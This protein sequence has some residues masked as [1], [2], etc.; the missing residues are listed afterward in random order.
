MKFNQEKSRVKTLDLFEKVWAKEDYMIT[1][2]G[3]NL[4]WL[5]QTYGWKIISLSMK[6]AAISK[7]LRLL[8]NWT[9]FLLKLNKHHGPNFVVKYL[10]ASQLALM[11]KISGVPFSSL[12]ELEP[13]LPL[14]RLTQSGLPHFLSS[15]DRSAILQGSS[16][17]FQLWV[18]LLSI[19]RVLKV[20]GKLKL[21]TITDPFKGD[22]GILDKV[23]SFLVLFSKKVWSASG[24]S[25][26]ISGGKLLPLQTA[27]PSSKVSWLGWYEDAQS[28]LLGDLS[29]VFL[30]YLR[31]TKNDWLIQQFDLALSVRD[32]IFC[33][34]KTKPEL[35]E[36]CLPGVRVPLQHNN[37]RVVSS[38]ILRD[39]GKSG[40]LGALSLKR[41]PAGKIRVFAMVDVW[42]QSALRPLHDRIFQFLA[43]LP[44]DGTFDQD[45]SFRRAQA[46]AV[47]AGCSYG[48]D[49]SAATDRLPLSLQKV[50]L[51]SIFGEGVGDTWASLLVDRDYIINPRTQDEFNTPSCLRYAVGQP[52]GALSSWG[53]LALTHHF[54]VQY[55]AIKCKLASSSVWFEGYELLGDDIVLFH[56][57][58][59]DL[60]KRV[61]NQLG[62]EINA[63]KSVISPNLPVLE[64]AKRFAIGFRDL[65]PLSFRQVVNTNNLYGRL[66]WALK[67]ILRG[68][69]DALKIWWLANRESRFRP[70][71]LDLPTIGLLTH[72][73]ENDK[74]D[75]ELL[76][77]NILDPSK[78]VSY[79][80]E[81]LALSLSL[82][83]KMI[84]LWIKGED[85]LDQF[86]DTKQSQLDYYDDQEAL[87]RGILIHDIL[88]LQDK[89][90]EAV[91]PSESTAVT[92]LDKTIAMTWGWIPGGS[93]STAS[94]EHLPETLHVLLKIFY[95]NNFYNMSWKTSKEIWYH[96]D[97]DL[98]NLHIRE[99][100]REREFWEST[101]QA[102]RPFDYLI[103]VIEKGKKGKKTAPLSDS[104]LLLNVIRHS[105]SMSL[106]KIV[107]LMTRLWSSSAFG[108][109]QTED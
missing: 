80:S 81:N 93:Y 27:S 95:M 14:P 62:V 97:R 10:K 56:P 69:S 44:N 91:D 38:L 107:F 53:M 41:E 94:V 16:K 104:L 36:F 71:R 15:N 5:L 105:R 8:N 2:S 17:V 76:I 83:R 98:G 4:K 26:D 86:L 92:N 87:Y 52:M 85:R 37:G 75:L 84:K 24:V 57:R 64:F 46:K 42:T 45:E 1:L 19:Y 30:R 33:L 49:L 22:P 40:P 60:Y 43:K 102:Q 47:K 89:F 54:I 25:R 58:V 29:E 65:S 63:S 96:Y 21:S 39:P 72:L 66:D 99:L 18:S 70:P 79:F 32:R 12:R 13:D 100:F 103:N 90:I 82:Q 78:P 108:G 59:A 68:S 106:K 31:L 6:S 55:C 48:Y 73:V 88:Q 9:R 20:P 23:S 7:R 67:L 3:E 74:F 50:V 34:T 101:L 109:P 51:N 61:M 28:I 11:K 77:A 35:F